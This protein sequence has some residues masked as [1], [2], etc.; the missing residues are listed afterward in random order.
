MYSDFQELLF[1]I[2]GELRRFSQFHSEASLYPPHG[3][4]PDDLRMKFNGQY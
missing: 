3:T 4:C 1:F 2:D